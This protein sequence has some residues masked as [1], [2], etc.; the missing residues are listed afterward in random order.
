MTHFVE[1]LGQDFGRGGQRQVRGE[2]H[3]GLARHHAAA[4]DDREAQRGHV[5][6][7]GVEGEV[8]VHR[9]P[10]AVDVDAPVGQAHLAVPL[11]AAV[12]HADDRVH[13]GHAAQGR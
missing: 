11:G 6:A 1:P 2:A 9:V 10:E 8:E 4:L 12:A 7:R 13:L 3:A 5:R